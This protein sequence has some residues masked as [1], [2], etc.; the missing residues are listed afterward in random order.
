[1]KVGNDFNIDNTFGMNS[2]SI[3][4][5]A[6]YFKNHYSI[7]SSA[8]RQPGPKA[9]LSGAGRGRLEFFV[10]F[11]FSTKSK[12][13]SFLYICARRINDNNNSK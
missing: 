4:S 2:W 11:C 8:G 7:A 6:K 10:N 1:V 5:I 3:Q 12:R 9:E 13:T